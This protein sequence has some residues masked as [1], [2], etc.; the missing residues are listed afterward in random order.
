[1]KP[2][3]KIDALIGREGG[4]SNNALDAGGETMWGITVAVARA[5]GYAGAMR[6]MP[7]STAV[8]IYRSRYW[9]QPKFDLVDVLSPALADRLFDIGVNAGQATGVRFLQR[10]L[11]VLNQNQRAYPDISV[12]GGIGA[13]T[14]AA[15]KTF[16]AARGADGHRV[17]LG[18]VS[19][20]QSVYYIECA[21]KRVENETFEYGW[22][23]NRALGVSA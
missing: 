21:E 15:L 7:R 1:M 17:L 22:Q 10:A 14:I 3:E 12:D 19:A 18:I 20:Q 8:Q 6:D 4:Y 23:L 13:M 2:D 5:S 16:L 9:L 11:N